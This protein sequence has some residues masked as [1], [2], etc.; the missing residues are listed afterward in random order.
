MLENMNAVEIALLSVI[1]GW[2]LGLAG[3]PAMTPPNILY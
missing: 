1:V 2:I 3:K